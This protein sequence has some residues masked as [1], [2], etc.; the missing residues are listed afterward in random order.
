MLAS[1]YYCRANWQGYYIPH[2]GA[3]VFLEEYFGG[4]FWRDILIG[5]I[6]LIFWRDILEGYS[7]GIFWRD[8]LEGYFGG[9]YRKDILV[10]YFGEQEEKGN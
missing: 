3:I 4:I 1:H 6:L 2:N 7:G 8:I 10:G 9:L 5:G